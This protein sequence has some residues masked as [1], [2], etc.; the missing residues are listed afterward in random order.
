VATVSDTARPSTGTGG[1]SKLP[2]TGYALIAVGLLGLVALVT[3]FGLRGAS[4]LRFA[5][6]RA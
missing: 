3:G 6:R 2:F 4:R 1:D 5:R